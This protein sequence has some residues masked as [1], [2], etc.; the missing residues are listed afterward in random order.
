MMQL[1]GSKLLV[2][3][4]EPVNTSLLATI[5]RR[6]GCDVMVLNRSTVV[7]DTITSYE[8]DLIILDVMMPELSGYDLT[9]Q[10]K[11]HDGMRHIP[12]V[13]LTALGDQQSRVLGLESG[14]E[15]YV[16]KPFNRRE[17]L[18]RCTNLLK[19]KQFN[20][21]L[22]QNLRLL[23]EYDNLTGLPNKK[24]LR[25][26]TE[27]IFLKTEGNQVSFAI[28]ETE[29]NRSAIHNLAQ[30]QYEFEESQLHRGIV[31]RIVNTLPKSALIGCLGEG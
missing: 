26:V 7:L 24:L 22:K 6:Q 28:C 18:A 8:P 11:T 13:L 12:V 10:I 9:K 15:D 5:F 29:L 17:L 16:T 27:A 31:E 19:L 14:A 3:D 1:R 20:D 4:D 23:Q 21:F 30:G 25:E 2:V